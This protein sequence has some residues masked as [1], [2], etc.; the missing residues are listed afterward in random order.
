MADAS[1]PSAA[2]LR[3]HHA[4]TPPEVIAAWAIPEVSA[5]YDSEFTAARRR[6]LTPRLST[7]WHVEPVAEGGGAPVV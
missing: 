5:D 6:T 7:F 1:E 4:D 3:E 2:R